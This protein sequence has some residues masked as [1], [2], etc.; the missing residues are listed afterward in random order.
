MLQGLWLCAG[1]T[2]CLRLPRLRSFRAGHPQ[3]LL[4]TAHPAKFPQVYQLLRQR[5]C[6]VH[7]EVPVG[8]QFANAQER[9][10]VLQHDTE[11]LLQH[12]LRHVWD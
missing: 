3:H 2:H 6:A 9:C 12:L 10:C 5:D 1:P 4:A 8:L 7:F 11:V